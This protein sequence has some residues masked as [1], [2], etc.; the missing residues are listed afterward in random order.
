MI[1]SFIQKLNATFSLKNLGPLQYV[2]NIEVIHDIIGLYICQI[3]YISNLFQ[4]KKMTNSKISITNTC[5]HLG[6]VVVL[7]L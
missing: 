2:L 5:T 3:W 6:L 4:K 7:H 1:T